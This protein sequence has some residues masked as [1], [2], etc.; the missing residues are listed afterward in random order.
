MRIKQRSRYLEQR[1]AI[2]L[3]NDVVTLLMEGPLVAIHDEID[4]VRHMR[5][6]LAEAEPV[7][8]K[9]HR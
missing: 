9:R 7:V 1:R 3:A 4:A 8:R 5:R 6:T 2:V